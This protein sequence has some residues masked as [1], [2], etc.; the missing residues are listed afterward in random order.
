M[1][2]CSDC[3]NLDLISLSCLQTGKCISY[4]IFGNIGCIYGSVD[5]DLISCDSFCW[6]RCIPGDLNG[7]F[8][9]FTARYIFRCW[10]CCR[11]IRVFFI[12]K[13]CDGLCLFCLAYRAGS[14]F[15][16][17]FSCR[18]FFDCYPL[19][20]SMSFCCDFL[21]F[22]YN[23]STIHANYFACR[24]FFCTG[25]FFCIKN[26]CC[27]MCTLNCVI[28]YDH[29]VNYVTDLYGCCPCRNSC[30]IDRCAG[31]C[32]R[33]PVNR[34]C[35]LGNM[36]EVWMI[37][38][39]VHHI[40][41]SVNLCRDQILSSIFNRW[42]SG[43]LLISLDRWIGWSCC[44]LFKQFKCTCC[45]IKCSLSVIMKFGCIPPEIQVTWSWSVIQRYLA[46][47]ICN[48]S[49]CNIGFCCF[50]R[51]SYYS[52][53]YKCG[54]SICCMS[55][56]CINSIA[57]LLECI[58]TLW[59]SPY[60]R[61]PKYCGTCSR[62]CCFLC[63]RCCLLYQFCHMIILLTSCSRKQNIS[64]T[65]CICFCHNQHADSGFQFFFTCYF[66]KSID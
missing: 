14:F 48:I 60:I 54:C 8:C 37:Q 57:D 61:I 24:S 20:K 2:V 5:I 53:C 23:C 13:F 6:C 59:K 27:R 19:T 62:I 9:H 11:L 32:G 18:R 28:G 52:H 21:C 49:N 58:L 26:N 29:I 51:D 64:V 15:R 55:W 4:C 46:I 1:L 30:K 50:V 16:S 56:N 65:L 34:I 35:N 42:C 3:N 45:C 43:D 22:L 10:R 44:G 33:I 40:V 12:R 41:C 63:S 17:F 38:C 47:R 7:I 39:R 36:S 25:C 31:F 66:L